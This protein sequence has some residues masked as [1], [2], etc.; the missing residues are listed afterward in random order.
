MII[1]ACVHTSRLW[2]CFALACAPFLQACGEDALVGDSGDAGSGGPHEEGDPGDPEAKC[3][4]IEDYGS[5]PASDPA[6]ARSPAVM[7]ERARGTWGNSLGDS[8]LVEISGAGKRRQYDCYDDPTLPTP[9]GP[10]PYVEFELPAVLALR[11][12]DGAWDERFETK[13][14]LFSYGLDTGESE[15]SLA[16]GTS[17]PLDGLHGTFVVPDDPQRPAADKVHISASFEDEGWLVHRTV[18]QVRMDGA[19]C[20]CGDLEPAW[21]GEALA[22]VRR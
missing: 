5:V 9:P 20:S 22:L 16:G 13:L 18:S 2:L 21:H 12:A 17:L 1:R 11:T 3:W 15:F 6:F 8:L 10:V 4:L 14:T 7:I 19:S